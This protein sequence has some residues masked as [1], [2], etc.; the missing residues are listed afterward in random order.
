MHVVCLP[1]R[2]MGYNLRDVV[3]KPRNEYAAISS[4]A[5]N[6]NSKL[7]IFG[8][9]KPV[10]LILL[11]PPVGKLNPFVWDKNVVRD[12]REHSKNFNSENVIW[13]IIAS[14]PKKI[15]FTFIEIILLNRRTPCFYLILDPFIVDLPRDNLF[16]S[17]YILCIERT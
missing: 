13:S 1:C 9:L 17:D 7:A 8:S 6:I 5:C 2:M 12:L 14:L 3:A 15:S 16:L 4:H 10:C 11:P